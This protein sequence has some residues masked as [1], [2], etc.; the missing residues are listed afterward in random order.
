MSCTS[1]SSMEQI[2]GSV[3]DASFRQCISIDGGYLLRGDNGMSLVVTN[4]LSLGA[5][6]AMRQYRYLMAAM[7]Q[8]HDRWYQ[9]RSP[10]YFTVDMV[11][12]QCCSK[13]TTRRCPWI[14]CKP[15][16]RDTSARHAML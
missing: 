10:G 2:E 13:C 5:L 9:L 6:H 12:S 7:P 1:F 8:K 16:G 3:A 4:H 14:E 11:S 15:V